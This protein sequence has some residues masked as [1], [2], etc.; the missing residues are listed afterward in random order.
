MLVSFLNNCLSFYRIWRMKWLGDW[1]LGPSTAFKFQ[2]SPASGFWLLSN[3]RSH[4]DFFPPKEKMCVCVRMCVC[5]GNGCLSFLADWTLNTQEVFSAAAKEEWEVQSCSTINLMMSHTLL[6]HLLSVRGQ[7]C[8]LCTC[9][10]PFLFCNSGHVI[11]LHT[12]SS[13]HV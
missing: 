10:M 5:I 11:E 2:R 9:K 7:W 12:P 8:W 1:S 13:D 4:T 3:V 6:S